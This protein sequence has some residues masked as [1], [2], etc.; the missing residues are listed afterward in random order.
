MRTDC[1]LDGGAAEVDV[2]DDRAG[3]RMRTITRLRWRGWVVHVV[4][5]AVVVPQQP[6]EGKAIGD[7]AVCLRSAYGLIEVG[8]ATSG[9]TTGARRIALGGPLAVAVAEVISLAADAAGQ[10]PHRRVS[11]VYDFL[12]RAWED[13]GMQVPF[14]AVVAAVRACLP[15]GITLT[16][17]SEAAAGVGPVYDLLNAAAVWVVDGR[18]PVGRDVTEAQTA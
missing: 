15:A 16:D 1:V 3:A 4:D 12:R 10:S 13:D 9:P 18:G 7:L 8:D 5:G 6:T 2:F 17:F 14:A 11:D